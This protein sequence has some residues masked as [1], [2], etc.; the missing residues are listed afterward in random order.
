MNL[1]IFPLRLSLLLED[2][3]RETSDWVQTSMVQLGGGTHSHFFCTTH[4]FI[5]SVPCVLSSPCCIS[6]V[7]CLYGCDRVER[8][9]TW[10]LNRGKVE[11]A[12]IVKDPH[13]KTL[14]LER[15]KDPH[16]NTLIESQRSPCE[17][18]QGLILVPR[19]RKAMTTQ[20]LRRSR[21]PLWFC[22]RF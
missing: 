16:V 3:W 19:S 21:E 15:L 9:G 4:P 12:L 11:N 2:F 17:D 8:K 7:L 13:V 18:A 5:S 6:A 20:M 22:I 1:Q 14:I 10:T